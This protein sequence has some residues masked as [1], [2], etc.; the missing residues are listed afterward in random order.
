MC[1]GDVDA[2]LYDFND[3]DVNARVGAGVRVGAAESGSEG[4]GSDGGGEED[5]DGG[6]GAAKKPRKAKGA[7]AAKRKKGGGSRKK[8]SAR[9]ARPQG[10]KVGKAPKAARPKKGE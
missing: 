2:A 8:P 1:A 10:P 7:G 9:S 6:G 3:V 4:G 5:E